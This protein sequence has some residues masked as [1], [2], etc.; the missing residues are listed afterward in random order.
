[1]FDGTLME[2]ADTAADGQ[3]PSDFAFPSIFALSRREPTSTQDV[4]GTLNI[5]YQGDDSHNEKLL[6][7]IDQAFMFARH[8]FRDLDECQLEMAL[9]EAKLLA[10]SRLFGAELYPNVSVDPYGEFTFSHR[11]CA[12]YVDIGVRGEG[13]L[14]YHVRN[15]VD[16]EETRFDDHVWADYRVPHELFTALKALRK[17]L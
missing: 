9:G 12:G 17:H 7:V 16:P 3:I 1:M 13:E 11:S 6:D 14:S 4:D 2:S 15:D 5:P 8:T 10:T